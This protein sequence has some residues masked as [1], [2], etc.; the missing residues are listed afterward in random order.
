MG[1]H[2]HPLEPLAPISICWALG[3][4]YFCCDSFVHRYLSEAVKGAKGKPDSV[5]VWLRLENN[6]LVSG[7]SSHSSEDC[8]FNAAG[9]FWG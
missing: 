1:P 5:E 8:V 9:L 2:G 4:N 6:R 3:K 7:D